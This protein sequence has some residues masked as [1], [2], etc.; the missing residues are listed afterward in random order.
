MTTVVLIR[1]KAKIIMELERAKVR[2]NAE[3]Y[4]EIDCNQISASPVDT[5]KNIAYADITS[6]LQ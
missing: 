4:E 6:K 5:N 1:S 2:M 3:I